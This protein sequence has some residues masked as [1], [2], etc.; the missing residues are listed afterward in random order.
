V[1]EPRTGSAPRQARE[2]SEDTETRRG[3]LLGFRIATIVYTAFGPID[4][5]LRLLVY[6]SA[7]AIWL[8]AWRLVGVIVILAGWLMVARRPRGARSTT[9]IV[10]YSFAASTFALGMLARDLGGI[11]TFYAQGLAFYFAGVA[12]IMPSPW[13]RGL[14]LD[15]PIFAVYFVTIGGL[16]AADPVRRAQWHD[17]NMVAAFATNVL[18]A[19]GLCAFSVV[20][21]HLLW[22]S[23]KQLYE[24]RRL[25]RYRLRQELG[26]GGM[27]EVWLAWD[28]A[29]HRDVALKILRARDDD[30]SDGDRW[31]RFERE[32]HATSALTSPHTVRIF[33][34]GASDDGIAYIAMERLHGMDLDALVRAHG[35]L[36]L[37]RAVHFARQACASLAEA[38]A[39]GLVHRDIKPANLFA[40]H[41]AGEEDFVKVLDFGVAR[42]LD[43][44]ADLTH[45]GV[46]VG[47]PTYMAPEAFSG[48]VD[49][50]SD[51][52]SM[53]ATLYYLL[54]GAPPF[55]GDDQAEL[56]RAHQAQPVVPP[57]ARRGEQ[58]PHG[59]E[60]LVLRCLSK[61]PEL[62]FTDGTMLGS[63]LA[64]LEEIAPWTRDDA[65]AWWQQARLE[66]TAAAAPAARDTLA[67]PSSK[68]KAAR[69]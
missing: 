46:I 21:G 56:W 28:D 41:G 7:S 26:R 53:G 12:A 8:L 17:A 15:L 69:P 64:A 38:H 66:P 42:Q 30:A 55:H 44:P 35:P 34:Y 4:Q 63:A 50:A 10:A 51:V 9:A 37:R 24:A 36:D 5:A 59:L 60:T 40:L 65:K 19:A 22:A 3:A 68:P 27:N 32:A 54:T 11:G 33:D 2:R 18:F 67:D 23:R 52:Y 62:R 57:S 1:T 29:L 6:P 14:A 43:A 13:K 45:A 20:S 49:A 39:R 61:R 16:V 58:L 31:R 25:G 47:T 48:H